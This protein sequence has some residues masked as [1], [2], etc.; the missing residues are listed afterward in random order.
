MN[1]NIKHTVVNSLFSRWGIILFLS[2]LLAFPGIALAKTDHS[3]VT[4]ELNYGD[5]K[6]IRKVEVPWEKGL[7]A[8]EAL[9][10]AAN[11]STHPVGNYVFVVSIDGVEGE[12]G[13]MAWYYKVNGQHTGELAI[14]KELKKGDAI[15]WIYTRDVCSGTVDNKK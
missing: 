13:V 8:L 3:T 9:V 4:V 7:T 10:H 15:T 12:R 14:S 11:V 2:F 1:T 6:E 5:D